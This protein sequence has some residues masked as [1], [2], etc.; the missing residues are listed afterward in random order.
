MSRESAVFLSYFLHNLFD[1]F[2]QPE[3]QR[4]PGSTKTG[5]SHGQWKKSVT[6]EQMAAAL[7][8]PSQSPT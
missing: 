2:S 8:I 4:A 6:Q 7:G 1:L 5:F 3:R